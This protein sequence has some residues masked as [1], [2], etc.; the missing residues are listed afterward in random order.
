MEPFS[1]F[2]TYWDTKQFSTDTK[3]LSDH[4]RLKLDINNN[5]NNRKLQTHRNNLL[6]NE[7][8]VNTEI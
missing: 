1:K 8:L 3:V 5:R 2:T 4:Y 6:L 7:K